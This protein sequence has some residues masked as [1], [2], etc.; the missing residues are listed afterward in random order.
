MIMT[1]ALGLAI[2]EISIKNKG[3]TGVA[4]VAET[5]AGAVITAQIFERM[6]PSALMVHNTHK[7]F[8]LS[9]CNRLIYPI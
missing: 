5:L 9:I 2:Y 8:H 3:H 1:L 4:V 6:C 7:I